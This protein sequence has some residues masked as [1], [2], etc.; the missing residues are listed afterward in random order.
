MGNGPPVLPYGTHRLNL[1]PLPPELSLW[2]DLYFWQGCRSS[3]DLRKDC[4]VLLLLSDELTQVSGLVNKSKNVFKGTYKCFVKCIPETQ[5][6]KCPLVKK[7]I[8][9]C[10]RR[11]DMYW[12]RRLQSVPVQCMEPHQTL[13]WTSY[14]VSGCT[15]HPIECSQGTGHIDKGRGISLFRP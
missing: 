10:N 2:S 14:S 12:T 13:G 4:S 9:T 3:A 7:G 8:L 11:W 5:Y 15:L 1:A 6:L